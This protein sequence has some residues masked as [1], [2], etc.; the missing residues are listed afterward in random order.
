MQK[1]LYWG[2]SGP[3][4]RGSGAAWD[5]RKSN[6]YEIYDRIPFTISCGTLGDCY[7]RYLVRIEELRTSTEILAYCLNTIPKGEIKATNLKAMPSRS[8][9]K[10]SMESTIQHF[11]FTS[12]GLRLPIDESYTATEAP[13]GEFGILISSTGRFH[14]DRIKLRA[15]GFFHLQGIRSVSYQHLLADIVTIIGTMDIVFGEV[16]R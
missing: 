10:N 13:K 9:M 4:L 7:D 16:D 3:M 11:K 5:L 2:F 12:T 6:P 8:S 14:P 15:P 1:G